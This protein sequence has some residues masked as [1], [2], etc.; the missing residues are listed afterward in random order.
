MTTTSLR[1]EAMAQVVMLRLATDTRTCG[2]TIDVYV[3]NGDVFLVGVCDTPEQKAAARTIA[4]GI[5]GVR[6]VVDNVRV[7]KMAQAI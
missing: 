3:D 5:C 2:Q 6:R 1:E 4:L 7:R